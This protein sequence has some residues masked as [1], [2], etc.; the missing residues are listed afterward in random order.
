VQGTLKTLIPL[1]GFVRIKWPV[2]L[3]EQRELMELLA[4]L[5]IENRIAIP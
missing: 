4:L 1:H 2:A 5:P 3:P